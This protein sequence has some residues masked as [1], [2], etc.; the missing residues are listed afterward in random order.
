MNHPKTT[1]RTVVVATG[2]ILASATLL[3]PTPLAAGSP[4]PIGPDVIVGELYDTLHFGRVGD[5]HAFAVG[6]DPCNVGDERVSWVAYTNQHPVWCQNLYK[7]V[8]GRFRQIGMSWMSHGFYAV[9]QNTCGECTDHT[10][11]TELGVG[12]SGCCGSAYMNGMQGNMSMR[13]D[14]N[15]HTGDFP[16]PWS[17]PQPEETIGK[18]IQVHDTDIDPDLNE[19]AL[20]FIEG[21][22][23]AADDAAAG[24]GNNGATYR[25][26]TVEDSETQEYTLD[27]QDATERGRPAIRAWKDNDPTVVETDVQVPDEGMF[28]ASAKATEVEGGLWHYEYA[29]FNLNS[30]R[31]AGSFT[32][33]VPPG[34][35][36]QNIGFHDIDYH[37]GE[38]YDGTDWEAVRTESAITWATEPYGQNPN[39]NA[40]RFSTLYNFWFDAGGIPTST[41]AT[42]GLFRPGVLTE[43]HA[44]TIGPVSPAIDCNENGIEDVCDVVCAPACPGSCG[45]SSDCNGNLVPDECEPDC[46]GNGIADEC[47]IA[48]CLPGQLWC[49]D[50]NGNLLPDTCDTDENYNGIPDEC[51]TLGPDLII[52]DLYEVFR[53]GR[54]G[55][56]TAYSVGVHSCN[57]G[58]ERVSW[59]SYTDAHPVCGQGMFRLKDGHFE[60]IG[61]GWMWHGFY[62]VSQSFCGPCNDP[63]DGTALGI[64]CSNQE[65]AYKHGIQGNM[66]RRSDVN[67][68]TAD[69]PYPWEAPE[70]EETI[71]KRIQVHDSDLDPE[72]NSGA[73]YFVEA[74]HLAADDMAAGK[75][76][77]NASHRLVTV[78]ENQDDVFFLRLVELEP[79]VQGKVDSDF[80]QVIKDRRTEYDK[81]CL[82]SPPDAIFGK[83]DP[84]NYVPQ[85]VDTDVETLTGMPVSPGVVTG[86]ARVIL[87]AAADQ[88]VLAGEILVA[89]FTDP[90]WTPYFVTAA[91]IVMDQGGILSHGSIVA[92]EYGIPAVV[93][94][95]FATQIIK[96]GQTIEVDGNRGTI[97]I[98]Q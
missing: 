97:K 7:L 11:G 67:A 47:D 26:V 83:F 3:A 76:R 64:G 45:G 62:A 14:V 56:I 8:D 69:F 70:P 57:L 82:I 12:C 49:S 89:P 60:Q 46:N 10:D 23:I 27:L 90:G 38:I 98:L 32:V 80:R 9:S 30:D 79:V 17:A 52:A 44:E 63:T 94:V 54:V 25:R 21:H 87:R 36:I 91:A 41:Q 5:I 40:L 72:L 85:S 15:A 58:D 81:N 61:L 22:F 68:F 66:S 37:S 74:Q 53:W 34:A 19:N 50:C 24:N 95:G 55:D 13:S 28:I 39:A 84:D 33:P 88:Q 93:N 18:R 77:N 29:V 2:A 71:G 42:I 92:R 75:G 4:D 35:A 86:K 31:S 96:T 16:Y 59:I 51:E 20:Y 65:S 48:N 78:S 73:L 6:T 1:K 43:V